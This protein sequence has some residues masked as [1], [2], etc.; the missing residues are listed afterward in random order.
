M[1]A[2]MCLGSSLVSFDSWFSI[3]VLLLIQTCLGSP[4]TNPTGDLPVKDARNFKVLDHALNVLFSTPFTPGCWHNFAVQVDWD[5][6]TLAVLF[7][8]NNALLKPVTKVMPN[9]SAAAGT[10]GQGEFHFGVLKV[11]IA[12]F[13]PF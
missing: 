9:L 3:E 10:A 1:M 11:F 2:R 8:K 4:F 13:G 12:S 7:S 6:R 5:N